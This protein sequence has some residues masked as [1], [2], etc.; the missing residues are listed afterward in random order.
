MERPIR[1]ASTREL[2]SQVFTGFFYQ[3]VDTKRLKDIIR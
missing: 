1:L 3:R 2:N